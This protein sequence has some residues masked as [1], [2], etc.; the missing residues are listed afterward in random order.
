MISEEL[1]SK[2][3]AQATLAEELP[4]FSGFKLAHVKREVTRILG[5]IGRDGIFDEYTPHDISHIN[6]V[7][8][9]LDWLIPE[10][11]QAEMSPADWLLV[12]LAVYFHDMGMLVTRREFGDRANSEF[13]KFREELF[14]GP[15]GV[16]Y[17]AQVDKLLPDRQERFLYQEF[18]RWKHAE[19]VRDW[20]LGQSND[21]TGV[22]TD[23][24]AQTE[25][26]L[27]PLTAR[28]RRDLALV[29]ES[30][31]LDDLDDFK[32][33]PTSRPY[34]TSLGET[35]NVHYAALVLRT[36]DLLHVTSDRTPSVLF[37]TIN[38]TN[39]VSQQE[40][41]RQRAVS[42]VRS[43]LARDK[44]GN[45]NAALPRDTVE[46]HA[47]FTNEDGF[48]G[49][50]S[51]LTYVEGQLKKT[52]EWGQLATKTQA[53]RFDIPWRYIDS[54]N[55]EADGFIPRPFEFTL[56]QARILD[57]LIG[58]TLYNDTSVVLRELVQNA[59]DAVRLQRHIDSMA[60]PAAGAGTVAIRWN[61]RLRELVVEDNG[62]GM[63]QQIV[64]EHLL[65]VGSSR[66]QD[67]DFRKRFPTFTSISR[68]GIGILSAFMISDEIEIVTCSPDDDQARHL[69]L[70]SVHGKYLVRTLPKN[71]AE[72]QS[73]FP[74]GTRVKLRVRPSAELDDVEAVARK[75]IVVPGCAV[76]LYVDANAE[77]KIGSATA[78]EALEMALI[79]DDVLDPTGKEE[80]KVR[81]VEHAV[82][83][84][85]IAFAVRW[86]D[87][88]NKWEFWRGA[89][90]G[91]SE[92]H[93]GLCVE[94]IR[95]QFDTPGFVGTPFVAL[96]NCAGATAP[97][98][99]VARSRLEMTKE[100]RDALLSAYRA[101]CRH[102]DDERQALASERSFT[103][104]W[105]NQEGLYLL[106]QL[107]VGE[108]GR[109]N[110]TEVASREELKRAAGE[111][112][113]WQV[114]QAG[115]RAPRS[116]ESIRRESSFWTVDGEFFRS[117]EALFREVGGDGSLSA[118]IEALNAK[119]LALPDGP[120]VC[121]PA[122]GRSAL[123]ILFDEREVDEVVVKKAQRRVDLRWTSS[124]DRWIDC[125]DRLED[126]NNNLFGSKKVFLGRRAVA[127]SGL[128]DEEV[129]QTR[130][131]F[132]FLEGS[133]LTRYLV[134]L[135][136]EAM[137]APGDL[138]RFLFGRVLNAAIQGFS[139]QGDGRLFRR[140]LNDRTGLE[141]LGFHPSQRE[142]VDQ[143]D[144]NRMCG[145]FNAC[146]WKAFDPWAWD[147]RA[148]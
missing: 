15:G 99:N 60:A 93:S 140:D 110:G 125:S 18:V 62:T 141:L 20:I 97:R 71:S 36:A 27:A 127:F 124:G 115:R 88:Y 56:D 40:W 102:V 111:L 108:A 130:G 81:I 6:A 145:A 80:G 72:V 105:A 103:P 61:S 79:R 16:D 31:H 139:R 19:R 63:T 25:S 92:S 59:L 1:V 134:A 70:R 76:G 53:S 119:G 5:L 54:R 109:T 104:A 46:I 22:T 106:E 58:H 94:G 32:K 35:A 42:A 66:Y 17:K 2:A 114:E 7:L 98:T 133:P 131:I 57:L 91:E 84:M 52:V 83:G 96:A 29:C 9:S 64:E 50:T 113:I 43:Q 126:N 146:S 12:V 129:V 90:R 34:G 135:H 78:R 74:H 33:Y 120:V 107:F 3:E 123:S 121:L 49:L 65:K 137:S 10:K 112:C 4:A 148:G 69:S 75:W 118:L 48:F 39:P 142:V 122:F 14:S 136:G 147:R 21:H 101:Y 87:W 41:C 85:T 100:S 37:H 11:T 144:V 82:N 26:L 89:G 128:E 23:V 68:F 28:F 86:S 138:L 143:F 47:L 13:P 38:P 55:V 30:H 45:P 95:V 116:A 77:I 132:L 117:A 51:Y 24:L 44:E 73:I 8:V 67:A